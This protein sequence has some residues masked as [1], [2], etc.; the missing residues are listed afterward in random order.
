MSTAA[1]DIPTQI[2]GQGVGQPATHIWLITA[3]DTAQLRYTTRAIRV[4]GAGD[5]R[6]KT[7]AGDDV[8]IPSVLA[9]ETLP[10]MCTMVY[11]TNTTAS[12]IMGMA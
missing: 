12:S 6:V 11:S 1:T 8:V 3:S 9:G 2:L 5:L 4:G 7:V 10:I